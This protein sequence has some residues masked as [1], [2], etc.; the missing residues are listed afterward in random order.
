VPTARS[1]HD[2]C[3]IARA[4]DV[5]GERWALLVVRELLLGPQRFSELRQ[6][7]A[8]TS[9]NVVTDRLR[10]LESRG[11]IQRRKLAPPSGSWVYELTAWGR[12]LEPILLALGGWGL[13][14]PYPPAP[15]VL[16]PTSVLIY[17]RGCSR[18][19]PSVRSVVRIAFDDQVWTARAED[20][21]LTIEA[22]DSAEAEAV[23]AT[24]PFTFNALIGDVDALQAGI[25]A[26]RITVEGDLDAP[27]RLLQEVDIKDG[28]TPEQTN[29][30]AHL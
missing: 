14:V 28:A 6:A 30:R 19:D 4:L 2:Q 16:T 7:L 10:E 29:N 5:V 20:G 25:D 15:N 9:A 11:V 18:P 22:G 3:G 12:Q 1:Y 24:D 21:H 8:N 27:R 23:I 17:L 13:E 26:G